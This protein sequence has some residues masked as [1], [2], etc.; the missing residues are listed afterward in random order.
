MDSDQDDFQKKLVKFPW[1][2]NQ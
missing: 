1:T 2:F